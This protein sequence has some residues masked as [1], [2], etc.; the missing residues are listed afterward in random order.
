MS[1]ATKNNNL[2]NTPAPAGEAEGLT[3][4]KENPFYNMLHIAAAISKTYHD[5]LMGEYKAWEA[6]KEIAAGHGKLDVTNV[7]K[8][9]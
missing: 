3:L 8:H 6:K 1:K 7:I 2:K 9:E 4:N 5:Y